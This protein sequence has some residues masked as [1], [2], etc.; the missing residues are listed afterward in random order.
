MTTSTTKLSYTA[1]SYDTII[2]ELKAFIRETHPDALS[3]FFDVNTG[4]ALLS[5]N[6]L[7]G[8]MLSV[9]QD[10]TAQELFL[11]TCQRYESGLRNARTVGYVPR[12]AVAAEVTVKS[13]SFPDSLTLN[14]GTFAAGQVLKGQNGL[15]YE[16]LEDY[17]V[18][19]GDTVARLLLHEGVSYTEEFNA[20]AQKNQEVTV[21]NGVVAADSWDVY[22][23]DTN[24]PANLWT[25]VDNVQFEGSATKTYDSYFDGAGRITFRFG[26]GAAGKIPNDVITVNYR[27]TK[28]VLGNTPVSSIQGSLVATLTTPGVG[29]VSVSFVNKDEDLSTSGGTLLHT[30]E[31]LGTTTASTVQTGA[32]G[33]IPIQ[34]GTAVITIALP[35]GAGTVV[36]Q[37]NG[38]GVFAVITNTSA[39]TLSTSTITYSTGGWTMTF[40]AALAAGGPITG[41]YYSITQADLQTEIIGAAVGGADRESLAE[42]KVNI[43]AYIRSQDKI[44]SIQD[45][46]DVLLRVPGVALVF[47]DLWLTSYTSNAVKVNLWTSELVSFKSMDV[48]GLAKGNAVTYDRYATIQQSQANA[49]QVYMKDRTLLTVHNVVIRPGMTWVDI[50]LG[51]VQ[52]AKQFKEEVVRDAI[53]AAVVALF[54]SGTGFAIRLSELYNAIRDATGVD[55]FLL[56]RIATGTQETSQE[57]QGSTLVSSAVVSGTL[58]NPVISPKSVTI[59]IEQTSTSF[60]ILKDNGA[61]QLTAIV[62]TATLLAGSINYNTG[63]WS[64]TFSAN[65]I[66]NQPVTASYANVTKDYRRDQVVTYDDANDPDMWPTPPIR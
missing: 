37:D 17:V 41:T 23:G 63:A 40:D 51:N 3:D 18:A 1:R 6:A 29:T 16:L 64:A 27:T 20:V 66:P 62:G 65:L 61:G 5:L 50:Y 25:Q 11:A 43:P 53:T 21:A 4:M 57:L 8:E 35:G 60:I 42:L 19:A 12:T 13:I 44:I 36:A 15:P 55:Y 26:D 56:E 30:N 39:R 10:I 7:V 28:G 24:N 46:N 45:Y 59:T 9:G 31:A 52:Y 54:E 48:T 34:A 32:F 49:V 2:A 58:L 33:A 22:V 38:A 14:G 47:T